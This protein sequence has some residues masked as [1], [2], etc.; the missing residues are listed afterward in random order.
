MPCHAMPSCMDKQYYPLTLLTWLPNSG[1]SLGVVDQVHPMC[2]LE[3]L[4][5]PEN[6]RLDCDGNYCRTNFRCTRTYQHLI[7]HFFPSLFRCYRWLSK[8]LE[9][10]EAWFCRS[11]KSVQSNF[12]RSKH[13]LAVIHT[14]NT[15]IPTFWWT[16]N[17]VYLHHGRPYASF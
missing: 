12:Y 1:R 10:I 11:A 3:T 9:S 16:R 13:F 5:G 2:P 6:T 15:L 7:D 8:E 4:R 17:G 14:R